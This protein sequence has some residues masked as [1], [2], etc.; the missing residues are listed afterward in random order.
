MEKLANISMF[1]GLQNSATAKMQSQM[2]VFNTVVPGISGRD[3]LVQPSPSTPIAA[4]N[5]TP[6]LTTRDSHAEVSAFGEH[7]QVWSVEQRIGGE[8]LP[9]G[10]NVLGFAVKLGWRDGGF[11]DEIYSTQ[12]EA[13]EAAVPYLMERAKN[14]VKIEYRW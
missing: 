12:E 5:G 14:E 8:G 4:P 7:A 10:Y 1:E 11:L 9:E 3:I 2:S 13:A 6:Y